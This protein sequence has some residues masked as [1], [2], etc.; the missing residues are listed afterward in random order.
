MRLDDVLHIGIDA[1]TAAARGDPYEEE[2]AEAVSR[3]FAADGCA[4]LV[5]WHMAGRAVQGVRS[6]VVSS[7][8]ATAA[9][10]PERVVAAV[11]AFACHPQLEDLLTGPL[12]VVHRTSDRVPIRQFWESSVYELMHA[13]Y[14]G[15]YPAAT[16][17]LR[18]PTTLQLLGVQRQG[19]DLS[20]TDSEGLAALARPLGAALA[21]RDALDQAVTRLEGHPPG[22]D[23]PFTRRE[24]ETI[25]LVACGWTNARIAHRLGISESGVRQRL[26]TARERVAASNR[27]ELAARWNELRR[28]PPGPGP[29]RSSR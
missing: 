22:P 18:T 5:T 20:E 24:A 23:G 2:L 6:V 8:A 3:R 15:R 16:V 29:S 27:T 28:R 10:S 9:L 1:A 7:S 13:D 19:G 26:A 11:D 14:G 4:G 25:A 21:F 17:L 12:H